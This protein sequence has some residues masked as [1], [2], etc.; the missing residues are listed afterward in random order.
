F[1]T[2]DAP[3]W[4]MKVF[5]VVIVSGFPAA[6]I[7]SWAFEI[8]PEGI[9]RADEVL[10]NDSITRKAGRKLVGVT[11]ALAVV[12][13]GLLAFQFLRSKPATRAVFS[14]IAA[15]SLTAMTPPI[16]AKSIAVLPFENL[17]AEKDN[18]YFVDG[19]QDEILTRLAKISALKVISRT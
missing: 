10:P 15:P 12:A 19:I 3:P 5:V 14:T 18:A 2:F 9:K 7:L 16:P 13:A 17:S 8:T 11:V 6:L 4:V 1:P